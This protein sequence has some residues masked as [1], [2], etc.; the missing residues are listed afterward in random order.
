MGTVFFFFPLFFP[1]FSA[2][3]AEMEEETHP[4]IDFRRHFDETRRRLVR[5][6]ECGES[7]RRRGA[8]DEKQRRLWVCVGGCV[9]KALSEL[10]FSASERPE[11]MLRGFFF[12]CHRI[13]L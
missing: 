1:F 7:T 4:W 2:T 11:K 8:S 10:S 6:V 13:E 9:G 12:F 3:H 5:G